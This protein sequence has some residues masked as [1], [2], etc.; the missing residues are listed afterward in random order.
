QDK[1]A[2]EK[3]LSNLLGWIDLPLEERPQ[4]ILGYEPSLD[5]VCHA[6]EPMS[7]AVNMSLA[8]VDLFAQ[9]LT[10]V[11]GE[12]NLTHSDHGMADTSHLTWVYVDEIVSQLGGLLTMRCS[13]WPSMCFCFAPSTNVTEALERLCKRTLTHPD[14]F[15]M[16]AGTVEPM[17]ERYHF[18][19]NYRIAPVW[20]VPRMGYGLTDRA[21]G[22]DAIPAGNHNYDNE[23]PSMHAIFVAYGPFSQ[24]M[25]AAVVARGEGDGTGA[26]VVPVFQNVEIY[27]LVMRLLGL[28][29]T[30]TAITNGTAGFWDEFVLPDA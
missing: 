23:D 22:E 15:D 26:Y 19:R 3:K 7:K 18:S 29:A 21:G 6:T 14:Q 28:D 10:Q 16:S 27:N 4:P 9:N 24:G 11:L 13:G 1:Y 2:L 12:R 30:D 8:A 5:H 25:K 20:I 17:P